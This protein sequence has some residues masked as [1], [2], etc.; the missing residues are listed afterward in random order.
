MELLGGLLWVLKLSPS[1]LLL[2]ERGDIL[3]GTGTV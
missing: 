3:A 2:I 1:Q